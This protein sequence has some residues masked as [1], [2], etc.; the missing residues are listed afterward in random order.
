ML[1]FKAKESCFFFLNLV[2]ERMIYLK[3]MKF[4]NENKKIKD[5]FLLNIN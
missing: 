5:L 1:L 3:K 4:E 2:N